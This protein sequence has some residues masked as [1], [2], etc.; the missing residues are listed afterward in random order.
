MG[1]LERTRADHETRRAEAA[2]PSALGAMLD[3]LGTGSPVALRDRALLL[4][5]FDAALRR[6][7]IAAL[8][9]EHLSAA[10]AGTAARAGRL[11]RLPRSKGDPTGKGAVVALPARDDPDRCP[12]IALER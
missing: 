2:V 7:E 11:I 8:D 9:H 1:G 5:G 10:P 6:S 4:V 12:I 3:A